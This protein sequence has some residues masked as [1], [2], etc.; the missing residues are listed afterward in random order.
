MGIIAKIL[1]NPRVVAGI[2]IV[3]LLAATHWKA[4]VSGEKS[5]IAKWNADKLL[6]AE[7]DKQALQYSIKE[8]KVLQAHSDKLQAKKDEQAKIISAKLA[9]ALSE[10]RN[11][12]SREGASADNSSSSGTKRSCSGANL[13][14]EDAEFLVREASSADRV[15][16]E[17]QEC[18][19]KYNKVRDT[20][21]SQ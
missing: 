13:Y 18:Q 5:I 12:E 4:Y 21:N 20:I 19:Q 10:L 7:A 2:L 11:R 17:L 1:L 6:Q 16:V 8:S 14:R 3:I 9:T 15:K